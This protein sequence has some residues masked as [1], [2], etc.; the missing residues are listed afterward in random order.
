ML[1]LAGLEHVVDLDDRGM[2][3]LRHR[4]GLA[5]E[6]GAAGLVESPVGADALDRDVA[7]ESL[8]PGQVDLAHA[9]LSEQGLDAVGT[10]PPAP[11]SLSGRGR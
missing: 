10:D 3:E 7:L 8:V 11:P 5:P 1:A 9:A 6:A 4:P 2:V